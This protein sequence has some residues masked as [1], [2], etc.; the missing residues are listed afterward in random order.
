MVRGG[1]SIAFSRAIQRLNTQDK[2]AFRVSVDSI[3]ENLEKTNDYRLKVLFTKQVSDITAQKDELAHIRSLCYTAMYSD[4]GCPALFSEAFGLAKKN[5]TLNWMQYVQD[6][7]ARY[8]LALRQYDSAMI[9]ILRMKD[10]WPKENRDAQYLNILHLLGDMYF[11][12]GLYDMADSVYRDIYRQYLDHGPMDFWRPYVVMNNLGLIQV[13]YKNYPAALQWFKKSLASAEENLHQAYKINL[14]AYTK[15]KIA[16]TYFFMDSMSRAIDFFSEAEAYPDHQIYDDA[17]Q[18]MLFFKSRFLLRSGQAHDAL[19]TA[20]QLIP[21]ITDFEAYNYFIPDL[22]LHI[23]KVFAALNMP[24]SSLI[25]LNSHI[26]AKEAIE[27]EGSKARSMIIYA[28]KEH[29]ATKYKLGVYQKRYIRVL[30]W[31]IGL[32]AVIITILAFYRS[33]YRSK[34]LLLKNL[35]EKSQD[36]PSDLT[37]K[38]TN[39]NGNKDLE[40]MQLLINELHQ[41][42]KSEK[43]YLNSGL[44]I[45]QTADML[46]TNRTYLSAALNDVLHKSFPVFINE[47]RIKEA[48]NLVTEG[49]TDNHTIEALAHQ[50]GF[51]SRSVFNAVFKKQTGVTPSF[52]IAKHKNYPK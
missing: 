39:G 8:Y 10:M 9:H 2:E 50:S 17:K 30:L 32:I 16:E 22:Y 12:A 42:M 51:A 3:L 28:E 21:Q 45:N 23:S 20:R 15:T 26:E 47:Y 49:F 19:E 46:S 48:V 40:K 18:E 43:P 29:A 31:M 38:E 35:V 24:D 37:L 33:L 4:T 13:K 52:L 36:K 11:H 25:Y 7:W 14:M 41:L 1:D 44:T 34:M 27:K 6:R 5:K